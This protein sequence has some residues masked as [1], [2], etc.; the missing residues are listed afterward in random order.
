MSLGQYPSFTWSLSISKLLEACARRYFYQRYGSWNGW[1]ESGSAEARRAYQLKQ[2]TSLDLAFGSAIH[3]RATELAHIAE[4]GREPPAL[5]ALVRRTRH[6]LGRIYKRSREDFLADPKR[7]PMLQNVYYWGRPDSAA[8]DRVRRKIESCLP[9]LLDV[10]LWNGIRDRTLQ[11]AHVEEVD[12][13]FVPPELEVDGVGVFARP[14]LVVR[15]QAD[16]RI[17]IVEWKTGAPRDSDILQLQVYAVWALD[18][19]DVQGGCEGRVVYLQD[20]SSI[21]RDIHE[22][23]V[24]RAREHIRTGIGRMLAFVDDAETNRPQGKEQF[25]LV[26]DRWACR[27]CN[28]FELCE[29]ELREAGRFPWED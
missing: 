6:E 2:L 10:E 9:N 17:A 7:N 25:P 14:D 19:L 23:D 27:H 22:S 28:F 24:D 12:G 20:G 26:E 15:R 29:S 16:D 5:A 4:D 11:I 18:R 3:R 21:V 13:R 1:D 8:V